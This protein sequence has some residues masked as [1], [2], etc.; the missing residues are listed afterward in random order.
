MEELREE[1]REEMREQQRVQIR[2]ASSRNQVNEAYT[3]Q[4]ALLRLDGLRFAY[5]N[6]QEAAAQA[7]HEMFVNGRRLLTLVAQPGMGK[8]GWI[9][10]I[11]RLAATHPDDDKVIDFAHIYTTA[12]FADLEWGKQTAPKL[13]TPFRNNVIHRGKL[14][15]RLAELKKLRNAI[16][17]TDECHIASDANMTMSKML[18]AMGLCSIADFDERN[19]YI[20]EVSATPETV[21]HDTVDWGDRAVTLFLK[22]GPIYKGFVTFLEEGRIFDAPILDNYEATEAFVATLRGWHTVPKYY[23]FRPSI[24]LKTTAWL[25]GICR[26]SKL[27]WIEHNANTMH[28]MDEKMRTAPLVDTIIIVKGYWRASKRLVR[29]HVGGAY[30]HPPHSQ[31]TTSASQGL[32]ARFADNFEYVG[33]ELDPANRPVFYGH[34]ASIEMYVRWS[35]SGGNYK[36]ADYRCPRITSTAGK[37]VARESKIS[38][39][40]IRGLRDGPVAAAALVPRVPVDIFPPKAVFEEMKALYYE[41]ARKKDSS[42]VAQFLPVALPLCPHPLAAKAMAQGPCVYKLLPVKETSYNM[43]IGNRRGKASSLHHTKVAETAWELYIDDPKSAW[44][45]RYQTPG[46]EEEEPPKKR[47]RTR[48]VNEFELLEDHVVLFFNE[49]EVRINH[50]AKKFQHDALESDSVQGICELL[51]DLYQLDAVRNYWLVCQVENV[52]GKRKCINALK[53]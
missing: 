22:A 26:K 48:K 3:T 47:T 40:S 17:F 38:A 23:I 35:E 8:T 49:R 44:V 15:S 43:Q 32:I 7:I 34:K 13:L 45:I 20:I 10:E 46:P 37:V 33:A 6:Q 24:T 52:V 2:R 5:P 21:L 31:N 29:T 19:I 16:I 42:F 14:R 9:A 28:N 39:A 41:T 50:A 27:G 53:K 18:K 30:E 1:L 4:E 51:V 11:Q 25:K 12:G 36:E